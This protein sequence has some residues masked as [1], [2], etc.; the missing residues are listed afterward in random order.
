MDGCG[1]KTRALDAAA[2]PALKAAF[3]LV[4][5][6]VVVAIMATLL[7]LL[8]PALKK[9][10][11]GAYGISC[12]NNVRSLYSIH[13]FYASDYGNYMVPSSN[14]STFPMGRF[15]AFNSYVKVK[16]LAPFVC[17]KSILD[18]PAWRRDPSEAP[19]YYGEY[20]QN[21]YLFSRIDLS[22]SWLG[23]RWSGVNKVSQVILL[24]DMSPLDTGNLSVV[25]I[26]PAHAPYPG[27][28]HS[29]GTNFAFVD[30]HIER[31]NTAKINSTSYN[32][33]PWQEQ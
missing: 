7:A 14:P 21:Y 17:E 23:A 31:W 11:D 9:A 18:C 26:L 24:G 20:S 2:R 6:L 15:L 12:S 22:K 19:G 30:G 29:D 5:L 32:A 3:S 28:P 4:E 16:A 13:S 10:R 8:L 33:L 25:S 27:I 1:W